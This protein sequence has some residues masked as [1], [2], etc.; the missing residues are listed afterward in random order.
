MESDGRSG[1]SDLPHCMYVVPLAAGESLS[2]AHIYE[3]YDQSPF[4]EIALF[5]D[6]EWFIRKEYFDRTALELHFMVL[7]FSLV[8]YSSTMPYSSFSISF[9]L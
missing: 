8:T 2:F 5:A 4:V 7:L 3:G 9:Y 6:A 1:K